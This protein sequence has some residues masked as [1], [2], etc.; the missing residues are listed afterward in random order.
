MYYMVLLLIFNTAI[1]HKR[2]KRCGVLFIFTRNVTYS[3]HVHN[4]V[5]IHNSW[6]KIHIIILINIS[7]IGINKYFHTA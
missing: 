5:E 3:E 4:P 7:Y 6:C 2:Y 1:T